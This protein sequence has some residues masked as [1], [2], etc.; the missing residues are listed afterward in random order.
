M[1]QNTRVSY[2]ELGASLYMPCTHPKLA[3]I[4]Q[5]GTSQARS[6]VF[7][8]ED[9]VTEDEL[10]SA[11][12]NLR[13]SL[14]HLTPS[15]AVRRFIR[16]RNA[17]VLAEIL[18]MPGIEHIDGFV[19]PKADLGSLHGYK[20]ILLRQNSVFSIMPTLETVQV[21]D[22]VALPKIRSLLDDFTL[23]IVCLRIGGNDLLNLMGLKRLPGLIAYDTP[24]RMIIDQLILAFRPFGYNLSAPVFD[25]IDDEQTLSQELERDISYGFYAKT[26]IHPKQV[27]VIERHYSHYTA[28][29]QQH[30]A[31]VIDTHAAA[32]FLMDG[33]MME[34]SCHANWAQRTLQLAHNRTKN[35]A[36]LIHNQNNGTHLK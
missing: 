18:A 14:K 11:L 30:A 16:P 12:A 8:C 19:L 2:F 33:E 10:P 6:M 32:V 13:H 21:L 4:L 35:S 3:T 7:C 17:E 22:S 29:H 20:K 25:F 28:Q 34:K 5:Q 36:H 24:L 27:S 9:A 23:P 1:K 15:C 31:A 26:A